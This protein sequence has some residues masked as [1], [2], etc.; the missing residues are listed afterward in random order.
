MYIMPIT[1]CRCTCTT[2]AK[3]S[4]MVMKNIAETMIQKLHMLSTWL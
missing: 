4:T 3:V 2:P 1:R